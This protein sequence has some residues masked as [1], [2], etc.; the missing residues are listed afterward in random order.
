[1]SQNDKINEENNVIGSFVGFV[2]LSENHWDKN[3]F[4]NDFKTDWGIELIDNSDDDVVVIRVGD[5]TLAASFIPVPV[6]DGEAEQNAAA[7]YMWKGAV[8]AA[9]NHKAHILVAV[10]GD[11]ADLLERGKL[12][13]KAASSLL[14]QENAIAIYTEEAVFEP[15]F[16]REVASMMQDDEEALPILDWIWFGVYRTEEYS[17][18]YTYGM[19]K[20]EKEE[21]E[22]Y[23]D[24]DLNDIRNF[25]LEIVS[26]LLDCDVTLQ[27]GETISFSEEEEK[28]SIT[29]SDGIA[30]EGKTLKIEYPQNRE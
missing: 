28:L 16:Y 26:Y 2:L 1:M 24:A 8:E 7:N 22:V 10:L 14:K 20:F 15:D 12:F 23:A 9:K 19:K 29:F 11:K 13:T 21:I 25:M 27:D 4:I 17:G 5:M 30:L 6:P 3:K 18:I